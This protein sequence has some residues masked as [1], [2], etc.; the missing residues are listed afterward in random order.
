MAYILF[1]DEAK[2][3]A[4]VNIPVVL[5]GS[6]D[7][8]LVSSSVRGRS[9]KP[10][11]ACIVAKLSHPVVREHARSLDLRSPNVANSQSR[12]ASRDDS[13]PPLAHHS[14]SPTTTAHDL[15]STFH[16]QTVSELLPFTCQPIRPFPR[17][18]CS[19]KENARAARR[20]L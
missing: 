1:I 4:T 6:V 3:N 20:S 17:P 11:C 7:L 15:Y 2:Y 10:L 8:V 14:L 19:E 16:F 13:K 18:Y 9:Q 5:L 12:D